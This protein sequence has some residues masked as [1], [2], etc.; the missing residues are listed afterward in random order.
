MQPGIEFRRLFSCSTENEILNTPLKNKDNF[1]ALKLLKVVFI[2][3]VNIK[4]P[5]VVRILTFMSRINSMLS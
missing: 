5:T 2:L 4:M 3:L 1:L